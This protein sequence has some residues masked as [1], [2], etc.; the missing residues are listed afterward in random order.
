M[1]ASKSRK[2]NKKGG[3]GGGRE[4][5]IVENKIYGFKEGTN[6]RQA[7]LKY[8]Q[9]MNAKQNKLNH[10][11][12]TGS[13]HRVTVPQ[14]N[15]P[16]PKVSPLGPNSASMKGNQNVLQSEAN[17]VGD[18]H[19][20]NSCGQKPSTHR[21]GRRGGRKHTR[22]GIGIKLLLASALGLGAAKWEPS[23]TFGQRLPLQATSPHRSTSRAR[24]TSP[25]R[26]TSRARKTSPLSGSKCKKR[27]WRESTKITGARK[28]GTRKGGT[29]KGGTRKGGARKGGTRR[30]GT[31]RGGSRYV[32]R[33]KW[34][35]MS[36]G[37]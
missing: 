17:A 29:R 13:G 31:R 35:C 36:G 1:V 28:G 12:G 22:G 34:G 3:N 37:I 19:A 16:G 24:K 15:P 14:F 18:C 2:N 30:G 8:Q 32:F 25:H 27:S 10:V 26:S 20:N 5:K 6:Q 9:S 33:N 4:P 7:A 23:Q 11:G 21:G